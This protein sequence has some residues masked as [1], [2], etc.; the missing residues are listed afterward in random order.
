VSSTLVGLTTKYYFLSV[1]CCLQFVVLF[2]WGAPSDERTGLQFAVQSLNSPS[3]SEPE[4]IL[5]CLIRDSPNLGGQVPVFISPR[6]K[7]TQLYSR[8]LGSLYVLSYDSQCYGGGIPTLPQPGEPGQRMYIPQKQGGP[9]QSQSQFTTDG[10]SVNQYVLVPS[11]RGFRQIKL[12]YDCRSVGQ[13]VLVS[14][15]HLGPATNFFL[16]YSIILDSY[17]FN[18]VGGPL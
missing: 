11:L 13:S 14:G 8:V 12:Y 3:R 15:T 6:K 1:C 16:L 9:L 17:E 18:D 4:T 5:Y 10:Q 7:V 2:V